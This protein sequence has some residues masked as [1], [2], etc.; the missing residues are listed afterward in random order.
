MRNF[1]LALGVLAVAAYF[2]PGS[3]AAQEATAYPWCAE[4]SSGVESCSFT[5]FQQCQETVSG[6]GG[7]CSENP[8]YVEP[9]A[10]VPDD[11][12]LPFGRERQERR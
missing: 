1:A 11:E 8:A 10:Q 3:A 9:R 7:S 4:E 5:T 2:H 6:V 12:R